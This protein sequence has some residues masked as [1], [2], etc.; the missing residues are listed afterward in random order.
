MQRDPGL[1]GHDSGSP[2]VDGEVGTTV[3][4]VIQLVRVL[5]H[6]GAH[7]PEAGFGIMLQAP[8]LQRA[9][10]CCDGCCGMGV[11]DEVVCGI[12]DAGNEVYTLARK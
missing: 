10:S 9:A 8:A 6:D 11:A 2:V 3:S 7:R 5:V 4:A 1:V 12:G